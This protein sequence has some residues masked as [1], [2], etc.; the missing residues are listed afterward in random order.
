M[1]GGVATK[2]DIAEMKVDLAELRTDLLDLCL[3]V[4]AGAPRTER[5]VHELLLG[6]LTQPTDLFDIPQ[7]RSV[8]GNCCF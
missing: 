8:T 4:R 7:I 6:G 3:V 2:A 5:K 1:T